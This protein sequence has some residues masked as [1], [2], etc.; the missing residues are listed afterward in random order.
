MRTILGRRLT[1][2]ASVLLGLAAIL[3]PARGLCQTNAGSA[4]SEP[5]SNRYLIVVETSRT[6][7]KR[8]DGIL[9]TVNALI[10]NGMKG[11]MHS[12]DTLG[13]WT[14][15][16]KLHAG[17]FPLQV[18]TPE[19]RS[20]VAENVAYFIKKAK[21]E[22]KSRLDETLS[23]VMG[24][25]RDSDYLTVVFLTDGSGKFSGTPFDKDINDAFATWKPEQDKKLMPIMTI[26][27]ASKGVITH[28]AVVPIPW[29][30]EMPPLPPDLIAAYETAQKQIAALTNKPPPAPA[31]GQSLIVR[32]KKADPAPEKGV[33]TNK[34]ALTAS[35]AVPAKTAAAKP[36]ST[37]LTHQPE[38]TAPASTAIAPKPVI[39]SPGPTPVPPAIEDPPTIASAA[40]P[41]KPT[42]AVETPTEPKPT[43]KSLPAPT[44]GAE[45]KS[46]SPPPT[47]SLQLAQAN[48][49]PAPPATPATTPES[50]VPT[51]SSRTV[52]EAASPVMPQQGALVPSPTIWE[53][54]WF[55]V[56]IGIVTLVTVVVTFSLM[57]RSRSSSRI[58]LI[59]SS[60]DRN[61][62]P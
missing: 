33:S 6:M 45:Q 41:A 25:V 17:D 11:Q 4:K 40:S 62:K 30:W 9:D 7:I 2:C 22:K 56:G 16:D 34:P 53:N 44:T 13:V 5:I 47:T 19:N 52:P 20:R 39:T 48:P 37:N 36:Q 49:K 57:R 32:G 3:A 15:N 38:T 23:A 1:F 43:A 61:A 46:P 58:S 26:L 24:L 50:A 18:W 14:F 8:G 28:R 51:P 35:N 10:M 42:A 12:G 29:N 27:R 60:Y 31:I 21:F 59:T 55:W 54:E